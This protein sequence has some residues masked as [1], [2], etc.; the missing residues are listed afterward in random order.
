MTPDDAE[1][2]TV[3]VASQ[4]R[5]PPHT[6]IPA[7]TGLNLAALREEVLKACWEWHLVGDVDDHLLYGHSGMVD[8]R[9]GPRMLGTKDDPALV[10]ELT[11]I[12]RERYERPRPAT[13]PR[14]W[15]ASGRM[16]LAVGPGF[17]GHNPDLHWLA[18]L[19]RSVGIHLG[20]ATQL[21]TPQRAPAEFRDN[22]TGFWEQPVVDDRNPHRPS[23]HMAAIRS[24]PPA[25]QED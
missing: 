17:D 10:R 19:G 11:L 6:W 14:W 18:R 4:G 5:T 16:L 13:G 1:R 22:I 2:W 25:Q 21:S 9:T 23:H 20:V 7:W 12:A 8:E 24:Y 15:P 3:D